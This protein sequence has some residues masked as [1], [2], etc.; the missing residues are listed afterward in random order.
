M[1]YVFDSQK[2]SVNL[3]EKNNELSVYKDENDELCFMITCKDNI[4]ILFIGSLFIHKDFELYP[5]FK[6]LIDDVKNGNIYKITDK[7][8]LP[9]SDKKALERDRLLCDLLNNSKKV[10]FIKQGL[11]KEERI[12]LNNDESPNSDEKLIIGESDDHIILTFFASRDNSKPFIL[13]KLGNV[14]SECYPFNKCFYNM[15]DEIKKYVISKNNEEPK[16]LI[17]E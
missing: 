11:L 5:F 10:N 7:D 6:N 14:Y 12:I 16:K 2:N 8:I 13:F 15:F 3:I 1:K 17:M 9:E 4:S